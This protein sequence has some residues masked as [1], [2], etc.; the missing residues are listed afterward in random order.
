MG[1]EGAVKGSVNS[2]E[3]GA[4]HMDRSCTGSVWEACTHQP[5]TANTVHQR[6]P[7]KKVNNKIKQK[8]THTQKIHTRTHTHTHTRTHAHKLVVGPFLVTTDW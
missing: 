6:D 8:R 7:A 1:R 5:H 4:M 3:V 2:G